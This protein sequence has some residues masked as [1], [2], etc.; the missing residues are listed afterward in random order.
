M[1]VEQGGHIKSIKFRFSIVVGHLIRIAATVHQIK[2]AK[3]RRQPEARTPGERSGIEQSQDGRRRT[4]AADPTLDQRGVR[5]SA[6]AAPSKPYRSSGRRE[7]RQRSRREEAGLVGGGAESAPPP[8]RIAAAVP[9][10]PRTRA[11]GASS[12]SSSSSGG[13]TQQQHKKGTASSPIAVNQFSSG[14]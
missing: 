12:G 8:S 7:E 2:P 3:T 4:G 9:P 6:T 1:H 11:A 13:G 14:G 10:S 5:G